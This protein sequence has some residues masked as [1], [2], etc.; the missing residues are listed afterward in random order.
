MFLNQ[1]CNREDLLLPALI[2]VSW[3]FSPCS[4]QFGVMIQLDINPD[5]QNI[6]VLAV[7]NEVCISLDWQQTNIC[8]SYPMNSKDSFPSLHSF[9]WF[10]ALSVKGIVYTIASTFAWVSGVR[11]T[12]RA[13]YALVAVLL[14]QEDS[15]PGLVGVKS[16]IIH[17][18]WF[19]FVIFILISTYFGRN[20]FELIRYDL[21]IFV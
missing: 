21:Q 20:S 16:Q 19:F 10:L 1:V 9:F 13:L 3:S 2:L 11:L 14:S 5:S 7:Q 18:A 8:R 15:L 4:A 12:S 6:P 17:I